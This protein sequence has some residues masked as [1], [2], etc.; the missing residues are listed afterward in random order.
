MSISRHRLHV[1]SAL[2]LTLLLG[3]WAH[4]AHALILDWDGVAWTPGS[5]NNSYDLNGD[6]INDITVALTSQNANVWATGC[7]EIA[8]QESL[9][10]AAARVREV[11]PVR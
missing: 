5:L 11:P 9:T 4:S 7:L 6:G 3:G 2:V 1:V 10:G 8:E